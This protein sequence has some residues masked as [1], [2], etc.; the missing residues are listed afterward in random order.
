MKSRTKFV[1]Q[2]LPIFLL[3]AIIGSSWVL[4]INRLD[5]FK[6]TDETK[7]AFR[8]AN[9]TL[10]LKRGEY[11]QTFQRSHPGVTTMWAGWVGMQVAM[12]D[13]AQNATRYVENTSYRVDLRHNGAEVM[14]ILVP[15]RHVAIALSMLVMAICF[16]YL[17]R[18]FG[19]IPAFLGTM[20][21]AFEPFFI[22]H[23]RILHV[24]GLLSIFMYLSLVSFLAFLMERKLPDLII[25]GFA[26]GLTWLSKTPGL[27]LVAGIAA[28]AAIFWLFQQKTWR[29]KLAPRQLWTEVWPLIGW[30][31]VGVATFFILWP[32]MWVEP[33]AILKQLVLESIDYA[34]GGHSSPVIF[35]GVIYRD[36]II[37]PS[38]WQY[39]PAAYLW[40]AS[41]VVLVGLLLSVI[42]VFGRKLLHFDRK[43]RLANLGLVLFALG[44]IVFMTA[45]SK[46]SDRYVL[47]VFPPLCVAAG[48]G[49]AALIKMVQENVEREFLRTVSLLTVSVAMVMQLV[50]PLLYRPYYISYFNPLMGGARRAPEVLQIGWGE[51]LDEAARYINSMPGAQQ[52]V[53]ASWY[54]RV[55]SEF[56]VGDTINIEDMPRISQGELQQI[57]AADYIVI[58]YHQFQRAMPENLLAILKDEEPIHRLWF[59]GLEYV[60]IYDPDEF[61]QM[62]R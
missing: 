2:I 32:A 42:L 6:L 54:E 55:F 53:V 18:L 30:G 27:Y 20:L 59:D 9:F 5:Q 58:Y 12:P 51:G 40:R 45:G 13:Y 24:D 39:Y 3:T 60:R 28:V 35:N 57:L 49:W 61:T 26:A 10:A 37:P 22:G 43:V 29:E 7:W 46:R 19:V 17:K 41:P 33:V 25:S 1:Q 4:R 21:L 44:Y 47:P 48:L 11:A 16:F 14:Q 52:M 8:S 62:D 23:T 38:V 50:L 15:A 34:V 36:G 31:A 56:F